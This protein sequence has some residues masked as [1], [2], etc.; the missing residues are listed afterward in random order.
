MRR[1]L[2]TTNYL[3]L[4][5]LLPLLASAQQRVT[6]SNTRIREGL[7]FTSVAGTFGAIANVI[8][9]FLIGAA[10]VA[11]S[12]GVFL[13]VSAGGDN[14]KIAKGRQVMIFGVIG[15]AMM[16]AFWGFVTIVRTSFL[17]A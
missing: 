17:G 3:L 2:L 11:V 4:T 7:T 14:E 1:I 16:L 9:P 6:I 8:I 12:W 15:L 5:S 13:Y 10:F